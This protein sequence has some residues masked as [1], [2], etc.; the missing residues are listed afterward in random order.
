M[1][2]VYVVYGAF[3][4]VE[5]YREY[6]D[7]VLGY[8]GITLVPLGRMPLVYKKRPALP[9]MIEFQLL[10]ISKERYRRMYLR[11][12]RELIESRRAVFIP[13]D[14]IVCVSLKE[15]EIPI[16]PILWKPPSDP[17][18]KPAR[19]EKVLGIHIFHEDSSRRIQLARFFTTTKIREELKD[20]LKEIGVYVPRD[21]IDL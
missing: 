2:Q 9:R 11:N 19:T 16:P 21:A 14:S 8:E 15:M 6:F 12:L 7:I 17:R 5:E 13:I 3:R 20:A 18:E 4:D 1:K 10:R